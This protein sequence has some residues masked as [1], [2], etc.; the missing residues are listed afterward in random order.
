MLQELAVAVKDASLCGL[1][2]TAPN[3]V[4]S[5]L[6]YF[7]AEYEAHIKERRCPGGVC[8]ALIEFTID[9]H[10]CNG[11][12]RCARE[13]PQHAITGEKKIPH[14]IEQEQCIQCGVC[15]DICR[16]DAVQVH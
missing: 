15:R 12:M 6:R 10:L 4:L 13:C 3:P 2:S 16:F 11:C 5:T 7:S 14:T 9:E 1:G 8:K